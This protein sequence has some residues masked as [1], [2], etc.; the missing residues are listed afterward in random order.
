MTDPKCREC[1]NKVFARDQRDREVRRKTLVE[2]AEIVSRA[3]LSSPSPLDG[4]GGLV[5]SEFGAIQRSVA[6]GV[7]QSL[8]GHIVAM[9]EEEP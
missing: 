3:S 9:S 2:V 7:C 4:L 8:A 1:L 5:V 6:H